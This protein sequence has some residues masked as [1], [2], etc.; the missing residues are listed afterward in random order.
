MVDEISVDTEIVTIVEGSTRRRAPQ[1]Q[2]GQLWQ[3]RRNWRTNAAN[4]YGSLTRSSVAARGHP[5]ENRFAKR[6]QEGGYV[7]V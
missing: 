3:C 4:P 5:A 7:R 6:T 1:H 2:P